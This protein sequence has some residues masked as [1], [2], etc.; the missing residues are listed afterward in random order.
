M[1]DDFGVKYKA[2]E[3]AQYLID[4][5]NQKYKTKTDWTGTSFVGF[6][7]NHDRIKGT[8]TI[9]M[10]TYISDA[11]I[12]FNIDISKKIENPFASENHTDENNNQNSNP[13]TEIQRKRLQQIIGVILYYAR[14]I[15]SLVL[16]RISKLSTQQSKATFSTLKA[17]ERVIQYL[18]TQPD[19]SITYHKSNMKLICYSDASYQNESESRSRCG[20]IFFLGTNDTTLINGPI[21]C[22]SSIIDVVTS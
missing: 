15:D 6:K 8:L 7:I 20:G 19:A 14:A 5:L 18:A 13:L 21:L 17:A 1:V 11:A 2:K 4:I 16:T 3:D 9:S 22:K 12:R 10:P